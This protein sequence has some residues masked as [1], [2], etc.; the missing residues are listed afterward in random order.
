[1]SQRLQSGASQFSYMLQQGYSEAQSGVTRVANRA[2]MAV[3]GYSDKFN[4]YGGSPMGG[5][6]QMSSMNPQFGAPQMQPGNQNQN[7]GYPSKPQK[8]ST[9]AFQM[10]EDPSGCSR[11][12]LVG[13]ILIVLILIGAGAGVGILLSLNNAKRNIALGLGGAD[14]TTVSNSSVDASAAFKIQLTFISDA[15]NAQKDAFFVARAKWQKVLTAGLPKQAVLDAGDSICGLTVNQR[16]EIDDLLIFIDLS[17]IDGPGRIL[18]SAAPCGFDNTNMPRVGLM[19]FDSADVDS[20]VG[21]G[22]FT[23]VVLHEMGHVLG[24]GSLWDNPLN[25]LTPAFDP[26]NPTAA[27]SYRGVQGNIGNR[28]VGASGSAVVENIGGPGTARGHWKDSTYQNELMT[29]FLSS[30]SNPLSRLTIRALADLGYEVDVSQADSYQFP[31]GRRLR[32]SQTTKIPYGNDVMDHPRVQLKSRRKG[33]KEKFRL[34]H[35]QTRAPLV[36]ST[37]G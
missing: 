27:V 36:D 21:N 35:A 15:S 28:E 26:Y 19:R 3:R 29:G 8:P 34:E 16:I 30:G 32:N 37:E 11:K 25:L 13:I 12:T 9:Q 31:S 2:S 4:G 18:G 24:I 1:M 6:S 10:D 14:N 20:L 23:N 22:Q 5:F 33:S 17:P 7:Q